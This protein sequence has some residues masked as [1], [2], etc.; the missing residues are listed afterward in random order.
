M[1]TS[2]HFPLKQEHSNNDKEG[3]PPLFIKPQ[4]LIHPSFFKNVKGS[5]VYIPDMSQTNLIIRGD[6][7]CV[8]D[9]YLDRSSNSRTER[10]NSS[11]FLNTF[12][13][14]TNMSDIWRTANPSSRDYSFYSARHN[15][16]TRIDYFLIDA[17]LMPHAANAKYHNIV[18]SDHGP[19]TFT[20][21]IQSMMKPHKL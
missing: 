6:L 9:P 13:N 14:N 2:Q 16:Y 3:R 11:A 21:N 15:S 12:I 5:D 10:S 17:K 19:L 18:I 1:Y 20:L 4:Y 7:N 8:L